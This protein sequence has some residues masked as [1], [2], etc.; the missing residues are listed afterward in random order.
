MKKELPFVAKWLIRFISSGKDQEVIEGDI[1]EV[2]EEHSHR[3]AIIRWGYYDARAFWLNEASPHGAT[4]Q[5]HTRV[6]QKTD[7]QND[8]PWA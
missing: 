3:N 7:S 8:I 1:R 6:H 5:A 2:L 4:K